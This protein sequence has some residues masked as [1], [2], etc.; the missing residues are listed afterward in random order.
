MSWTSGVDDSLCL[1]NR[2]YQ[3][4]YSP[5]SDRTV[6]AGVSISRTARR[7]ELLLGAGMQLYP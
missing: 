3:G 1:S 7:L 2:N 6:I 4:N 5:G